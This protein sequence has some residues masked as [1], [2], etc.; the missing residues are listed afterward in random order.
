M[1]QENVEIVRRWYERAHATRMYPDPALFSPD[2]IYRPVANF[3]E[4]GT[5][6]GLGEFRR[7]LESFY[8]A[9]GDDFTITATSVRDYG[10]AVIARVEFS[11]HARA[12]GVVSPWRAFSVYWLRDGLIARVEDYADRADALKAVGMEE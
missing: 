7:F 12:S 6:R 5:Y 3:T 11:G 8:E 2:F 9:W 10:D 1:S 4:S